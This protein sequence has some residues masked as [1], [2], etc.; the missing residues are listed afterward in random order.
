MGKYLSWLGILAGGLSVFRLLHLAVEFDLS[1]PAAL[2]VDFYETFFH[3]VAELF[4]P[5]L[6]P[7][8]HAWG[9]TDLPPWWREVF[10]VY[11]LIGAALMRHA[12]EHP[13]AVDPN[14]SPFRRRLRNARKEAERVSRRHGPPLPPDEEEREREREEYENRSEQEF[15]AAQRARPSLVF[16]ALGVAVLWPLFPALLFIVGTVMAILFLRE[17]A[18]FER[19]VAARRANM[20]HRDLSDEERDLPHR[21]V[22]SREV[23]RWLNQHMVSWSIEVLKVIAA[24]VVFLVA[25]AAAN[26]YG[27]LSPNLGALN[28]QVTRRGWA[29]T[30]SGAPPVTLS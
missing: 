13:D 18:Y 22:A 24:T 25:N 8:A 20:E 23:N 9:L 28:D 4:R 29:S 7:I 19:E 14:S 26:S 27:P 11:A 5:V 1:K 30:P 15:D 3:P 16:L 21:V 17:A 12:L 10:I 2:I 6:L